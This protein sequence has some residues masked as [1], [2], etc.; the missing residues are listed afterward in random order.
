MNTTKTSLTW[1]ITGASSGIG[2]ALALAAA[3]RGDNVTAIARRVDALQPLVD[4]FAG[5]VRAHAADVTDPS[6]L[7]QAVTGTVEAFGRLDV[8]VNNAGAGV[9]GAIEEASGCGP[10][11]RSFARSAPGA[12]CRCPRSSA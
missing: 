5:R 8:V 11:C 7:E 10:R 9:L 12:S 3:E 6:T 1:L 4:E 2:L